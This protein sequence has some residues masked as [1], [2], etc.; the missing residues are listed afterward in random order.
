MN[1]ENKHVWWFTLHKIYTTNCMLYEYTYNVCW[2]KYL[3]HLANQ[4]W[5]IQLNKIILID[6]FNTSIN[7]FSFYNLWYL[8]NSI[9]CNTQNVK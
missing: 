7:I 4:D 6:M 5:S 2:K 1:N 8:R 3:Q 9:N